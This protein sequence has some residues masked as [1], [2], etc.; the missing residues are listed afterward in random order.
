[1]AKSSR[2]VSH[3]MVYYLSGLGKSE[4]ITLP[5]AR[6]L[7]SDFGEAFSPQEKR[8]ESHTPLLIR[9]PET[10]FEPTKP[11]N[12]SSDIWTLACTIWDIIAQ[13]S[14]F[15]GFLTNED[16]MT[17][18][19]IDALGQLPTEWREKWEAHRDKFTEHGEPMDQSRSPYQSWEDRFET[20]V[21]RPR[22]AEGMPPLESSEQ[23]SLSSMLRSM[24]SFRPEDRPSAQQVLESEWM[25]KWALPEYEK[26]RN[27]QQ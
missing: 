2:Q 8:F 11:L 16:D 7:L 19:Q 5:E 24:L 13:R 20:S 17:C 6:I 21:Q 26:I 9:P 1:M 18:Q 12:F 4:N 14:L 10:R 27:T 25:V 3:N 23:D 22:I 15:E